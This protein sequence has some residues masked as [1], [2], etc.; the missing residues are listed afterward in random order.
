ME[1]RAVKRFITLTQHAC[2]LHN[3]TPHTRRSDRLSLEQ[4]LE[5]GLGRLAGLVVQLGRE[6]RELS[7]KSG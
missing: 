1:S 3:R 2:L 4:Y 7:T 5:L 6:C